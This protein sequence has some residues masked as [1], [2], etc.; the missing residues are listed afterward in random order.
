MKVERLNL[1][2]FKLFEYNHKVKGG[3]KEIEAVCLNNF[4][5]HL[6]RGPQ[7]RTENRKKIENL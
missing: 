3:G 4:K 1:F 7:G 6:G 5:E 2:L